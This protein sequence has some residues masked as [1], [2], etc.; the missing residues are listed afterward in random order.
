MKTHILA[1][2]IPYDDFK[3]CEAHS[4]FI[5]ILTVLNMIL[6]YYT[7]HICAHNHNFLLFYDV[8]VVILVCCGNWYPYFVNWN[9]FG[10][11][12]GAVSLGQMLLGSWVKRYIWLTNMASCSFQFD[13]PLDRFLPDYRPLT[14]IS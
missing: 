8:M 14:S 11:F 7:E 2:F 6:L 10:I 5:I 13:L 4:F 12:P 9:H 3:E 1:P